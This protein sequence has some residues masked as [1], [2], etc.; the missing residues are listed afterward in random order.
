MK[1]YYFICVNFNNAHFTIKFVE[2]IN[3]LKINSGNIHI[4]IVDNDSTE[5]DYK[6]LVESFESVNNIN[7]LRNKENVGYFKALNIGI[8]SVDDKDNSFF[9]IGN[10]DIQ[11]KDDFLIKLD[12]IVYNNDVLAIAPNIITANG[13]HQNPHCVTRVSTFRKMAYRLYFTNYYLGR[14]LYWLATKHKKIKGNKDNALYDKHCYIYM[15][16]G[17][18]YVLTEHFFKFYTK[19]DDRV[20]LWG[21]EAL[22]AGQLSAVGGK[23]LYNPNII[24]YHAEN[25]SVKKIPSRETYEI[26]RKS[27]KIYSKYL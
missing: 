23:L 21:E 1:N 11:F 15:G 18:S 17:A 6:N 27:Y 3:R 25:S 14:F 7:L 24:V 2:S 10:N 20:F 19:L 8:C 22:L 4:I 9:I 16:I 5:E 26:T 12:Q 13:Y